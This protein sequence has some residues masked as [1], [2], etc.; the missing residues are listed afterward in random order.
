[1]VGITTEASTGLSFTEKSESTTPKSL[2]SAVD[3]LIPKLATMSTKS[4]FPMRVDSQE[5]RG[6]SGEQIRIVANYIKILTAPQWQL[7]QY[8]V[9]FEPDII[10]MKKMRRE[11]LQQHR[12]MINDVAFDGTTLYSFNDL[13]EKKIFISKHVVTNDN[14]EVRLVKTSVNAAES[15]AFFHL[16]NLII[17]KLL[18]ISGLTLIGRNYYQYDRKVDMT[19]YNLTLFPGFLTNVSLREGSLMIN[20]DLSHKVLNKTTVYTRL[21]DIFT[22]TPEYRRAQDA[23]TRELLGQVVLTT[24]NNKTYKIDEIAWDK[25]PK[26]SFKKHNGKEQSLM[27]YYQERYQV[28]VKDA[29]QPLLI[30]KPSK[31]DRLGGIQGPILLIPELCCVTGISEEMRLNFQ[32]MKDISNYIHVDPVKRYQRLKDF[33]MDIRSHPDAKKEL[34][35]WNIELAEDLV[36]FDARNIGTEE[37]NYGNRVVK[38]K[39]EEADWSREGRALRHISAKN[40]INWIVLFAPKDRGISLIDIRHRNSTTFVGSASE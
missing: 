24:Y 17:R 14:I 28:E 1:D 26:F 18:E 5:K 3:K 33:N 10:E 6:V 32:F 25:D 23:A 8:H 2:E 22:H 40:L 15:P 37:I 4:P 9:S 36:E 29:S 27:Q 12:G 16:V 30:S 21:Q 35:K 38:Y 7:Y 34:K 13:G 11:L 20:V 39:L 19:T 31:K